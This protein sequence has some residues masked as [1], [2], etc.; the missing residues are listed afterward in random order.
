MTQSE[1]DAQLAW[2]ATPPGLPGSGRQRYAAAMYFHEKGVMP[3]PVLEIYRICSPR[4]HEDPA[5]LLAARGLEDPLR[6][7]L[8]PASAIRTLIAQC[9]RYLAGLDGPGVAEARS[10]LARWRDGPL[11]PGTASPNPVVAAHLAA[12]LADMQDRHPTFASAIAAA[13]PHLAWITYGGYDPAQIGADFLT[14]HAYVQLVGTPAP[15]PATQFDLGLF[16]IAPHV[17]YRDHRHKAPELYVPLTGPHGWRFRPDAPLVIWPADVPVWNEPDAP[18]LTKVGPVPF[19]CLYCWT[20]DV[21]P[22]AVVVPASDWPALEALR[23]EA[24]DAL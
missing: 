22:L 24:G 11:T 1:D 6:R 13:A 8:A 2:L 4:D 9:D 7:A 20:R 16:L 12:A 19:L 17:L 21:D 5:A 3:D 18:H 14:G 23:L 15:V 10:G